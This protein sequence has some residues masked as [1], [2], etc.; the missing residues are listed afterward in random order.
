[1]RLDTVPSPSTQAFLTMN[2]PLIASWV[3]ENL[4]TQLEIDIRYIKF[5]SYQALMDQTV[6]EYPAMDF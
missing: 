5:R 6:R 3:R 4:Q 1:M 2:L